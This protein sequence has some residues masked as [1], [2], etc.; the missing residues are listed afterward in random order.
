MADA[1]AI[2]EAA[3]RPTMRFVAV[4]SE[5]AQGVEVVFRIRELLIRRRTQAINALRGHLAEF[6]EV[7]QH[8]AANASSPRY[9]PDLVSIEQFLRSLTI[10]EICRVAGVTE[11]AMHSKRHFELKAVVD[12]QLKEMRKQAF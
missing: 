3:Q 4:K 1:E 12:A 2:C 10:R 7:V 6:G 11:Q 9:S 5:Q 8:G